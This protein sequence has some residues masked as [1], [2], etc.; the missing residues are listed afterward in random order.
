MKSH[1]DLNNGDNSMKCDECGTKN[2]E[3]STICKK[4]WKIIF[5]KKSSIEVKEEIDTNINNSPNVCCE[6]GQILKKDWNY[7]PSCK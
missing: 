2:L 3:D 5:R 7:C 6:C 1:S 4:M